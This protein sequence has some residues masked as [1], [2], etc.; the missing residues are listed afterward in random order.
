M[1]L[2]FTGASIGAAV[3]MLAHP[4]DLEFVLTNRAG[5]RDRLVGT[6]CAIVG[7]VL[8]A[9][10]GAVLDRRQLDTSNKQCASQELFATVRWAA[11]LP[12]FAAALLIPELEREHPFLLLAF[13]G[14]AWILVWTAVLTLGKQWH[15]AF[16]S[17]SASAER[18]AR[19]YVWGI[20]LSYGVIM[21]WY[22][23]AE[24][25][26]AST[27]TFDLG[28][29]VNV[30]ANSAQGHWLASDYSRSGS[31]IAG[32]FDPILL[33]VAAFYRIFPSPL[34][35]LTMQ[36]FWLAAGFWPLYLIAR[37][38]LGA[39]YPAVVVAILY[40]LCPAVHGMNLFDFHSLVFVVPVYLWLVYALD[41]NR[42]GL[43]WS[44]L[45]FGLLIREDVPLL[46]ACVGVFASLSSRRRLGVATVVLCVAYFIAV[47]KLVMAG[48]GGDTA[49]AGAGHFAYY[50]SDMIPYREE[51]LRGMALSLL[52]NPTHLI[53]LL[54]N[55]QKS[56][57]FLYILLPLAGLPFFAGRRLWLAAYG[58]AFV[59]LASRKYV[60]SF[61]F[62][63][64][65][66]L[67]PSLFAIAPTGLARVG[68]WHGWSKLSIAR[69]RVIT[70]ILLAALLLAVPVSIK[71]GAFVPNQAFRGG[72][73]LLV[74]FPDAA[75]WREYRSTM[76]LLDKLPQDEA[77]CTVN[78]LGPYVAGRIGSKMFPRCTDVPWLILPRKIRK[79]D[80]RR[81]SGW[82]KRGTYVEQ[83][84]LWTPTLRVWRH[85]ETVQPVEDDPDE[86]IDVHERFPGD[87]TEQ[88]AAKP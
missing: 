12:W 68:D 8:L 50:Y 75:A 28:I 18:I 19:R 37:R 29:Y 80:E 42:L 52:S 45:I 20:T 5:H 76:Q 60:F 84:D 16:T 40:G 57:Y 10:L 6:A 53:P 34:T 21:S 24:Y 14:L 32:H 55:P 39:P 88:P 71:F 77:V 83:R 62:Q 27:H 26:A 54:T 11:S 15:V 13:L 59:G 49:G 22:S 38:Q 72:W 48:T 3:F 81:V 63:Y 70:T 44:V 17:N 23:A 86:E 9:G 1:G 74:R 78:H 47:K 46:F 82:V 36:S 7:A 51:G 4:H 2:A 79:A 87:E 33:L 61:H 31:H 85:K 41:T 35:L 67:V 25:I 58:L 69:S 64:S 56:A 65:A 43:Y 73:N 30:V 66:V